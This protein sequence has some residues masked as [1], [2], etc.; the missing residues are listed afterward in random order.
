MGDDL[1]KKGVYLDLHKAYGIGK[2]GVPADQQTGL[3][4]SASPAQ[5]LIA[6]LMSIAL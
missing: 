6:L 2:F 4:D 3:Q 5:D 1:L